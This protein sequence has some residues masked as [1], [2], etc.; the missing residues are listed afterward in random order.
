MFNALSNFLSNSFKAIVDSNP[1]SNPLPDPLTNSLTDPLTGQL[2]DPQVAEQQEQPK[3]KSSALGMRSAWWI[4]SAVLLLFV[5]SSARHFLFRSTAFDLG[6]YDQVIFLISRGLSPISSYLGFH[7]MGN[8]AAYSVYPLALLYRIY[9]SVYWLFAVQAICLAIGAWPTWLLARQ[10]GLSVALS[11]TLAIVYLLYPLIFNL[12]LFDFHPEVMALPVLLTAI[13]LARADRI[14]WFCLAIL[15]VLGCKDALSLTIAAMGVWLLV[16]EKRRVCGSFALLAGSV[17]F[18]ATTQWIIPTLSGEEAAA[19]N[20]YAYLGDSVLEVAQNLV[21]RPGIIL[22]KVFSLETLEY[23]VEILFPVIWGL[24]L[25]HLVPLVSAIPALMLNILSESSGQRDLVHQYSLPIFPFLLVAVI[26]ALAAGKTWWQRRR[27]IILW[28]LLAFVV[29]ESFYYYHFQYWKALDTWKAT[30][31]A[32]AQVS[33]H[34]GGVM[35][36]NYLGA[37]LSQRTNIY[38]AY[39]RILNENLA[40]IDYVLLNLRHPFPVDRD[41]VQKVFQRM[42][43]QPEFQLTYEQDEVYLFTRKR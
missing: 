39:P 38:L 12:N 18:V 28:S 22:G 15:F 13:W 36:D 9:P 26:A 16:F 17:W 34:Q 11:R 1:E 24:S 35:A 33:P 43:K 37:H 7:H 41:R 20:R 14:G 8:H 21:L 10:A 30:R 23:L 2:T 4:G 32:V 25:R 42:Q 19:V 6:I 29:I 31:Q 40:Q 5:C 27:W 3:L